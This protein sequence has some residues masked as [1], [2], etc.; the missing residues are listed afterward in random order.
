MGV[1]YHVDDRNCWVVT[2]HRAKNQKFP[3]R[4][5]KGKLVYL[6][7]EAFET[8]F[9]PVPEGRVV[10]QTCGQCLCINPKHLAL[11]TFDDVAADRAA[12]G[13]QARGPKNGRSKLTPEQV[14]E[15][16]RSDETQKALAER[17][18]VDPSLVGR[19]RRGELW[20]S[21]DG[22]GPPTDI[23]AE[24]PGGQLNLTPPE[25]AACLTR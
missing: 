7:R 1:S 6:H 3:A 25:T 22:G 11:V 13:V 12:R 10:R 9:G 5:V 14:G 16:R 17:F 4:R 2:S 21:V 20:A 15:I 18:G 24:G 23:A 8:A 19:I